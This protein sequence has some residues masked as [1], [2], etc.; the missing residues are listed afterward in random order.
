MA[1]LSRLNKFLL[2]GLFLSVLPL[3]TGAEGAKKKG[4][5]SSIISEPSNF[6]AIIK[7]KVASLKVGMDLKFLS[8]EAFKGVG[9]GARYR[10]EY[11]PSY[12][13]GLFQRVDHWKLETSI[14][15]GTILEDALN[16][17]INF[18][19]GGGQE[20]Y[21]IRQFKSHK[22]AL[23]AKPYLLR[24]LP[25]N[26][27]R[28]VKFL[29]PGDFCIIPSRI[30]LMVKGR[31]GAS[32][33]VLKAELSSHFL[34]S[35]EFQI[36]VLRATE[37]RVRLRL[38]ANRSRNT[39]YFGGKTGI[40]FKI[41]GINILGKD[42]E[43][44]AEIDLGKFSINKERGS[45]FMIDY[46]FDLKD[47][48]ARAAYDAIL[49]SNHILKSLKV[50]NIFRERNEVKHQ[51]ISDAT[52]AEEL[53]REDMGK[54]NDQKRVRRVFKGFNEYSQENSNFKVGMGLFH[55]QQGR[56][57]TE[58]QVSYQ[59]ASGVKMRYL[60]TNYSGAQKFKN[61][62]YGKSDR[63]WTSSGLFLVD[64]QDRIR[65]IK[66]FAFGEYYKDDS[67]T[68]KEQTKFLQKIRDNLPL[69]IMQRFDFGAIG[70]GETLKHVNINVQAFFHRRA[71]HKLQDMSEEAIYA[72]LNR[73]MRAYSKQNDFFGSM[74]REK[75]R[76]IGL[77][78]DALAESSQELT[79]RQRIR[80]SMELRANKF[81][82]RYGLGF[83]LSLLNDDEMEKT[84]N[85][86]VRAKIHDEPTLE[87]SF[88]NVK[89]SRIYRQLMYIQS[90]LNE[91]TLEIRDSVVDEDIEGAISGEM[92]TAAISS[93]H[94][95]IFNSLYMD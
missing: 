43:A 84:V 40:G 55:Y 83:L 80:K 52:L 5:V 22:E 31:V 70:S 47:E 9:I 91:R 21:F 30:N 90:M 59:M 75:K 1:S 33:Q 77:L 4:F 28:A 2:L 60:F 88:G 92:P 26:A 58:N 42:L 72:A 51:V 89:R 95:Q 54:P 65:G 45:L 15:P 38:F 10:Y 25:T 50:F 53:V 41:F 17:P 48:K 6:K 19:M 63:L 79:V 71:F 7:D 27:D 18:Y 93:P 16:L 94:K 76:M 81:F 67:F 68:A 13:E 86:K 62:F 24:Q 29:K 37:D 74:E 82:N 69:N 32:A 36:H 57:Y 20:I 14:L 12:Q 11:E 64:R 39:Q 23:L 3:T 35:G 46:I 44:M 61:M 8:L 87:L 85:I 56:T 73:H 49:S 34:L 66:D 78:R